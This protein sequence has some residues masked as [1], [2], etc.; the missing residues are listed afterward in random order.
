MHPHKTQGI[1]TPISNT[2]EAIAH[3]NYAHIINTAAH[4]QACV[5]LDGNDALLIPVRAPMQGEFVT[6]DAINYVCSIDDFA[7]EDGFYNVDDLTPLLPQFMQYA[8]DDMINIFGKDFGNIGLVDGK[9]NFY[10]HHFVVKCRAGQ[11]LAHIGVGGQKNTVLFMITGHGCLNAQDGWE[12]RLHKMLDSSYTHAK[13]T[14]IDLAH[15]DFSGAYSSVI[16]ADKN[17]TQG[18][19]ILTKAS[20]RPQVMH[21]GNWKHNDP[22]QKGRTLV[23]GS[24][25]NGKLM[26]VY[27]KGKHLGAKQSRWT[28][29]ELEIHAKKRLIPFDVLLHPTTYF[30]GSYPYALQLITHA[31]AHEGDKAPLHVN[32]MP[33]VVKTCRISLDKSFSIIRHQFGKYFKVFGHVFTDENGNVDYRRIFEQV[34]TKRKHDYYPKRLALT[35]ALINPPFYAYTAD[36]NNKYAY[37]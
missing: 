9:F 35:H 22:E 34:Q 1:T 16:D 12:K 24:R 6:I 31:K 14:R 10:K 8:F 18:A 5:L 23:V 11:T 25:I 7:K 4:D 15:D 32:K 37:Q 17:E 30:C 28:R 2:G 29:S 26:R 33:T 3:M 19:F 27:E 13:I 20:K 21:F 36:H